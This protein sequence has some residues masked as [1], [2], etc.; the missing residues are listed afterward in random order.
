M[1]GD[2]VSDES[3]YKIVAVVVIRMAAQIQRLMCLLAS[4]F[5]QFR[6]QLAFWQKFVGHALIHQNPASKQGCFA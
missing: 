6:V 3:G 5:Q 1:V 2:V 4:R